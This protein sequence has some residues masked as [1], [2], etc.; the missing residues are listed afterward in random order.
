MLNI[1]DYYEEYCRYRAAYEEEV[2]K[3]LEFRL[4]QRKLQLTEEA[5]DT[6]LRALEKLEKE[7]TQKHKEDVW[8]DDPEE[9]VKKLR[10]IHE[11]FAVK[12]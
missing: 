2:A 8:Y 12:C 5:L 3:N 9:L 10:E 4:C 7:I 6:G 1:G 11:S